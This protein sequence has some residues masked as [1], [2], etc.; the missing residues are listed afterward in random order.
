MPD[1]EGY[2]KGCRRFWRWLVLVSLLLSGCGQVIS[3]EPPTATPIPTVPQPT[4][5]LVVPRLRPTATPGPATPSPIASPSPTPTPVIHVVQAGET[6]ISISLQYGVSVEAIQAANGILNPQTLQ[7]GQELIIPMGDEV[8]E[9]SPGLLL[10]TPTPAPV[11]VENV[12][13]YRTPVG[14][15]WCL[16]EVVNPGE[17]PLENVELRITL[18][19]PAG[20]VLAEGQAA[21]ALDLIPPGGRSPFGLLFNAPPDTYDRYLVTPLRAEVAAEGAVL[22]T[23]LTVAEVEAGPSGPLFEVRGQ[24]VNETPTAMTQVTV[25]VTTYNAAGQVTG[26]RQAR[27]PDELPPGGRLPFALSLIPQEAQPVEYTVVA[28]GRPLQP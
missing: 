16:G 13:F 25:I 9:G 28:E 10:P 19:D 17:E 21:A 24:V 20:A 2:S 6:L 23:P 4:V 3:R 12:A 7:I 27:L 22:Y 14:S 11:L 18:H 1:R 5:G 26:F 15:L 8:A